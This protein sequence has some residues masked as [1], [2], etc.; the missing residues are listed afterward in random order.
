MNTFTTLTHTGISAACVNPTL[1]EAH[2]KLEGAYDPQTFKTGI[3]STVSNMVPKEAYKTIIEPENAWISPRSQSGNL[4][5]Q[6][7]AM[8]PTT[9]PIYQLNRADMRLELSY[10]RK[11]GTNDDYTIKIDLETLPQEWFHSF[12]EFIYEEGLY[13]IKENN[14]DVIYDEESDQFLPNQGIALYYIQGSANI[15][16]LGGVAPSK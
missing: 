9:R 13:N 12:T 3:Y 11:D 7:E 4:I 8:I 6:D 1:I 2:G 5:S 10:L 14:T 16:G 15:F